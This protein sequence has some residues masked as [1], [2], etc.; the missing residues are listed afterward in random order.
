MCEELH[1]F[2]DIVP[3]S[4][5]NKNLAIMHQALSNDFGVHSASENKLQDV[6]FVSNDHFDRR[7]VG[8]SFAACFDSVL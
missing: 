4:R 8:E 5:R 2:H 6:F 7:T 1:S 3:S